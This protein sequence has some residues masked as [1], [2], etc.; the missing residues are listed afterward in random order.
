MG[1]ARA[2]VQTGVGVATA[3][4]VRPRVL[5]V[6]L[7]LT[8]GGTERLVI[9]TVRRLHSRF[10][11]A[12]CCL[13]AEGAWAGELRQN[14][15]AVVAL[16]RPAGFHPLLARRL[17]GVARRHRASV[18]HCHHYSPFVY[19]CLARA[20]HPGLR[21]LFT[22]HGRLS[23]GPPSPKRRLANAVFRHVPARVCVV[24]A[25]LRRHLAAEGF[26][27]G[28]IAVVPN[29]IEL[30]EA[31]GPEMRE[32][33][34]ATLDLPGDAFVIGTVG[35][36]DP[37]KDLP[38]LVA[39]FRRF[40]TDRPGSRLVIVGDGPERGTLQALAG[41]IPAIRLAGHRRDARQL[42]SAFDVYVSSS[43]FE[44]MS[45][46]ILE[47]MAAGLPVIATSVGGTPEIVADGTTGVLVA[48]GDPAA[49]AQALAR[50]SADPRRAAAM[51]RAGRDR[52]AERF[53]L[54][55]MVNEYA[56][57]YSEIGAA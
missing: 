28:D 20:F 7:S 35:R 48:P 5:Q 37:V 10:P 16:G 56:R 43:T 36:L 49:M 13:D 32:R 2:V 9:E 17:A 15:V 1:S 19:G 38:T 42:M 47:A 24:S 25:D 6:V 46:T 27:G 4:R 22:E 57:A 54:E 33:A 29:G 40:A 14:G 50:I 41:G 21:V 18:L 39:A 31:G 30:A 3:G 34:R 51:G 8:P 23:D 45:L 52:V 53:T 11:M 12:V 44:G 55:R 26:R